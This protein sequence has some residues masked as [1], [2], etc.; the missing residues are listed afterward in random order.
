MAVA[1][2][3]GK[4]DSSLNPR[5]YTL[6]CNR[7]EGKFDSNLKYIEKQSGAKVEV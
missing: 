5:P 4:L 6:G 1:R 7:L 2:L 3:E